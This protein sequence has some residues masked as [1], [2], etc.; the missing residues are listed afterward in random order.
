MRLG[1]FVRL[2]G[3]N[4]TKETPKDDPRKQTDTGSF[5]Q[6]DEPW[7][8]NPEKEQRSHASEADLEKWQRSDTH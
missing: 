4:M 2:G 6:T 1:G 8:G 7:K 3:I 5:K